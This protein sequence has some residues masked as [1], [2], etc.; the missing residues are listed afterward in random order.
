MP[1]D[2]A[3]NL[4]WFELSYDN[5]WSKVHVRRKEIAWGHQPFNVCESNKNVIGYQWAKIRKQYFN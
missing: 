5:E 2:R 1:I 4:A 3:A